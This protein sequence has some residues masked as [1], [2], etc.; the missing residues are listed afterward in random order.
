M[1]N[2][3][4]TLLAAQK[5][6]SH[7]PYV[8]LVAK[9]R[10]LGVV[11]L[12][13]SRL[14]TGAEP[15]YYH[16]LTMP[17]DGSLIRTRITPPSDSKKLYRQ[18]VTDPG[19]GSDYSQWTYINQ[20]DI[21]S[22]AACSLG[23]EVSLFWT[24]GN[25]SV[26]QLKSTDSG[27][28]WG[29]PQ[30]LEYATSTETY[31]IAAA[32]K[33]NGD[34]AL[35]YTDQDTLR[36]KKYVGGNWQSATAWDKVTGDLT[37]VACIYDGDWNLLVTGKDTSGNYKLWSLV[38]GDGGAVAAGVWSELKEVASAPSDGSF[39]YKQPFMAKPDV[40]RSF[41]VERFTGTEAYCRPFRSHLAPGS[42]FTDS[43]WREP[44]P[45]NLSSEYGLAMAH[46][47]A[48]L[49]LTSPAGVW[50]AEI[51]EKS[52]DL[53]N[54]VLSIRE[55]LGENKGRLVV[56]LRNDDGRYASPGEED[57]T[58]LDS[59]CEL[60]LSPGYLTPLGGETSDGQVFH[61]DAFEHTSAG[62]EASLI[63]YASCGWEAAANW[64]ARH[65]FRW[66]KS[67]DEMNVKD[68]LVFLLGR[69]GIRLE[70]K[71]AS[72]AVTTFYPDFT[73]QP[74]N[75]G[76][77][78]IRNLLSLVPDVIFIEG[79]CAYLVN[80]L[81]S[82]SPVY[83][84]GLSH[85][86]FEGSYREGAWELSCIQVEGHDP[87]TGQPI[88]VNSIAWGEIAHSYERLKQVRDTNLDSVAAA[89]ARGEALLREA[90][91]SSVSGA[92]SVPVNCGQQLYDVIEITDVRAGLSASR[93][94]V[95]GLTLFY[96][97]RRGQYEQELLLGAV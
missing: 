86:I 88:I 24:K 97:T 22:V 53:Q 37:G 51:G 43:L 14:Y 77:D 46:H 44:E 55:E 1:R 36:V 6:A 74:G 78:L 7:T 66:N 26:S 67:T 18:R 30:V 81:S 94:R 85:A 35:F 83:A 8:T 33:E 90:E 48:Y 65:Q 60:A 42:P 4:E 32:Y 79:N 13:F 50:R 3:S 62:G 20:Y 34:L 59:G 2:L 23:S 87:V 10:S 27:A 5:K 16:A 69:W 21:T 25:R 75:Q 73:I 64:R 45:F 63:L 49:W 95:L 29:S 38:Y 57:L 31:G 70:V 61:L 96:D 80:P 47:G 58:A 56:A 89:E 28:N 9:N 91:I 76:D 82:D 71:S 84:Y 17:S 92:I 93:R 52:L 39:E 11:N 68:I 15:D 19:P 72:T 40:C 41:F 12:K 54:D